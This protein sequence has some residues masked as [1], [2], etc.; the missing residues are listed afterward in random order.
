MG[1]NLNR[2]FLFL[3]DFLSFIKQ[4]AKE[5]EKCAIVNASGNIANRSGLR[6]EFIWQRIEKIYP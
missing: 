4:P 2:Q 3:A 5:N 6:P 1:I